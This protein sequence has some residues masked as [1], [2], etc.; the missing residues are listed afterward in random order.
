[1]V[2]FWEGALAPPDR[3]ERSGLKTARLKAYPPI[4]D[5]VEPAFDGMLDMGVVF[6]S[7]SLEA[8]WSP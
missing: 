3:S 8:L 2:I 6:L 1:M 5:A 4:A 7:A